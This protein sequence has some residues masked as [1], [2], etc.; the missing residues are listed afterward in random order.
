MNERDQRAGESPGAND[1]GGD[2]PRQ[3]SRLSPEEI[4]QLAAYEE[5]E[6]FIE[7]PPEGDLSIV[8]DQDVPNRY[9]ATAFAR[10][11]GTRG[12]HFPTLAGKFA[13]FSITECA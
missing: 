13:F 7:E 12:C 3:P 5:L 8:S 11:S 1:I 6:A 2:E 10:Q 4:E 9:V